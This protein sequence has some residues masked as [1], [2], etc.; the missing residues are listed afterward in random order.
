MSS[1]SGWVLVA[2]AVLTSPALYAGL[3][4]GSMPIDVALTRFLL[5]TAAC[6]FAFSVAGSLIWPSTP[7]PAAAQ[8]SAAPEAEV[9]E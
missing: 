5:T 7:E 1:L 2:A 6:W 8:E 9:T 4:E 3:V